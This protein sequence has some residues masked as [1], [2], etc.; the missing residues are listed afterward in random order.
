MFETLKT[1][2]D[3]DRAPVPGVTLD[4]LSETRMRATFE[5]LRNQGSHALDDINTSD[6]SAALKRLN[7]MT[8]AGEVTLAA[9]LV[10][11]KYPQQ[12]FPQLT[13]D[14]SVHHHRTFS[15]SSGQHH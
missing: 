1:P 6:A 2:A 11:G 14:V 9:Y 3:V 8:P 7:L 12:H 5:A 13:V 10:L 15:N 4:D